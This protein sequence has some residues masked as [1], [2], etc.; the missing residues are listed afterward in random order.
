MILNSTSDIASTTTATGLPLS[1]S[2]ASAQPN[3]TANSST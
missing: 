3:S 1:P 2:S